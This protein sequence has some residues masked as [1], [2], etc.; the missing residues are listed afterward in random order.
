MHKG[1]L[2]R[3][4]NFGNWN[5]IDLFYEKCSPLSLKTLRHSHTGKGVWEQE[6]EVWKSLFEEIQLGK[7][8]RSIVMNTNFLICRCWHDWNNNM[9]IIP[10]YK[11]WPWLI[12]CS[13]WLFDYKE[14]KLHRILIL[15]LLSK[16]WRIEKSLKIDLN[17]N[18]LHEKEEI[19]SFYL[20]FP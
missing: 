6:Q 5:Y 18:L 16:R 12:F 13:L 19:T 8:K 10:Q 1:R 11:I 14:V 2:W 15:K 3:K 4:V 20:N 7:F 17:C 9:K